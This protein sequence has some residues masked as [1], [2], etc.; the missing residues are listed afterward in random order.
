MAG[1][2]TRTYIALGSNLDQPIAQ[3][4][5][6]TQALGQLPEST[7]ITRS[8]LYRSK[9]I[10]P[11]AQADYIN[12]VAAVDT[13]LTPEKL[14]DALQQI[15]LRQGR[16]RRVRWAA[17]TLDL[18]IL[19]YGGH[20]IDSARLTVPHP[21]MTERNFVLIPLQQIA[22]GL[23]LPDGRSVAELAGHCGRHDLVELHAAESGQQVKHPTGL[24]GE[25]PN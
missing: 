5:R 14:L 22:P 16:E 15:E 25:E 19:L 8:S 11:G 24:P 21:S 4:E 23:V 2:T 12:A 3:V 10:G 18:D 9:A 1:K 6:A 13:Q 17:R 20:Q 7:F